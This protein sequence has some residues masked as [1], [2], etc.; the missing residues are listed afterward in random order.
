MEIIWTDEA[1]KTFKNNINYLKENWSKNEVQNFVLEAFNSIETIKKMPH[2]G[3][4]DA[5][6]ECN[7]LL[8][9]KQI[10]LFYD[11]KEEKIILLTFWDNRQKPIGLFR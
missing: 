2:I 9:V 1:K 11:V 10:S 7:I 3:K 8:V 5:F 6:F 4:Y